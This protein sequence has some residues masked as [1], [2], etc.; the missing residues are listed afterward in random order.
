M[1]GRAHDGDERAAVGMIA[2]AALDAA[3]RLWQRAAFERAPARPA[4]MGVRA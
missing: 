1:I 3:Q 2:G 4:P